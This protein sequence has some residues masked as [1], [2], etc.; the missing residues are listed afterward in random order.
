MALLGISALLLSSSLFYLGLNFLLRK[1]LRSLRLDFKTEN[2]PQKPL[3]SNLIILV[4]HFNDSDKFPLLLQSLESQSY[5]GP[6][7]L[8]VV[9]DHSA[10][11]HLES[12]K[13][14]LSR[15]KLRTKLICSSSLPGKKQALSQAMEQ[16]PTG[17]IIQLDADV[18]L[19]SKF[20]EELIDK[21]QTAGGEIFLGLVRML[22]KPN[23]ISR[24]AAFEFLSLQMS[25]LALTSLGRPIMA[26]GAAMA[27]ESR[28][29]SRF[30]TVGENWASGDDSFLVQA[31]AKDKSLGIRAV[32]Q[33]SVQTDAPEDWTSFF[34]QRVRWG[35][36]TVAYPSNFAKI[37]AL[38]V[39]YCNLA[40][41]FSFSMSL[42]L[43]WTSLPLVVLA[44][45][46]KAALDY[47]LLNDF[48]KRT[49]Q[50]SLVKGYFLSAL[51]YPFY[52]LISL[53]LIALPV[54]KKWKGR[55]YR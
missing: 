3:E 36:K 29:W 17:F 33:A 55:A 15:T 27:Y 6:F 4:A 48:A 38:I 53:I 8:Y 43:S 7:T 37:V 28:I 30:K 35:A 45:L 24:F 14:S 10:Q 34:S 18:I 23:F 13:H 20:L 41:V 2:K 11:A 19:G 22:P 1:G 39:A 42:A 52:I 12:L 40:L 54:N 44:F 32:P 50:E 16:L 49:G 5:N 31:A 47:P 26:N 21:R 51:F 46:G 25:G 9:D